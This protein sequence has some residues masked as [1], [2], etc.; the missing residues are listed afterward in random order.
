MYLSKNDH[1]FTFFLL[2]FPLFATAQS[3]VGS[4]LETSKN[5]LDVPLYADI[6][7]DS[8]YLLTIDSFLQNDRDFGFLP[9]GDKQIFR[10]SNAVYWLRL[11]IRNID[12]VPQRQF[13]IVSKRE[14]EDVQFYLVNPQNQL[15]NTLKSGALVPYSERPYPNAKFWL[16]V[17]LAPQTTYTVYMRLDNRY[18]ILSTSIHYGAENLINNLSAERQ[19]SFVAGLAFFYLLFAIIMFAYMRQAL[20]FYYLL[21]VCGGVGYLMS[22]SGFGVTMVWQNATQF[23]AISD[24]VLGNISIMGFMLMVRELI[25]T[26]Q[27]FKKN[28]FILRGGVVMSLCVIGSELF[29]KQLNPAIYAYTCAIGAVVLV[30]ILFNILYVS[31]VSYRR[32]RRSEIG[33]FLISYIFYLSIGMLTIA[34]EFGFVKYHNLTLQLFFN[35]LPQIFFFVE[36]TVVALL[37]SHR[38]RKELTDQQLKTIEFQQKVLHQRERISRDLHDDVGSTLNSISVYSEVARRQIHATH[39]QSE[40]ILENIGASARQLIDAINDIVWAINPDNDDFKNITQR[41]R[42]FTAQ[43]MMSQNVVLSFDADA[44]LDSVVLSIEQRK[45]FYLLFKEAINNIFK[46]AR[47]S[48]LS[49]KIAQQKNT[50]ELKIADDGCGF[51]KATLQN[52]NGMKTMLHRVRDLN[53]TLDIVSEIAKGTTLT[54]RFP[55]NLS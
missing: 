42:L 18:N 51:D 12:T 44:G 55:T 26:N 24:N 10:P 23:D 17:L 25:K 31:V 45:N 52:G 13:F 38:I 21:Y 50:I 30:V 49:I 47:C 32:Y 5:W 20:F 6:L 2:L 33:I 9:N 34:T 4:S 46:H 27:F 7:A 37:L 53:G 22:T 8:S 28:D 54:V 29:K 43:I 3:P 48:H 40:L 39:P 11:T 19:S 35:Q 36:M 14:I 1:L 15:E 16:P 41:M